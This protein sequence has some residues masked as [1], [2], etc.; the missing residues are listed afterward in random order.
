MSK[1]ED[2]R[3]QAVRARALS[4]IVSD[5][6]SSKALA[7]VVQKYENE[8]NQL[9]LSDLPADAVQKIHPPDGWVSTA[10]SEIDPG[11]I[12]PLNSEPGDPSGIVHQD[13][14]QDPGAGVSSG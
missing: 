2:L 10:L 1:S 9:E 6:Q 14:T 12:E 7:A 11:G 5:D 13:A 8:A 4:Q 3:D